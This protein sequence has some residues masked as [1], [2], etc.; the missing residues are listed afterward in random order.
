MPGLKGSKHAVHVR[1]AAGEL[2]S[3]VAR[4]LLFRSTGV[5]PE[6]Y[7]DGRTDSLRS[8]SAIA[9]ALSRPQER[10]RQVSETP[11]ALSS[12]WVEV[13]APRRSESVQDR[14]LAQRMRQIMVERL[15][16]ARAENLRKLRLLTRGVRFG[17]LGMALRCAE[18]SARREVLFA[19]AR[20]EYYEGRGR[21]RPEP[22]KRHW[23]R[24][25]YSLIGC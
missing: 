14:F 21:G 1:R 2:T 24:S 17:V 23:R 25:V 11:I 4:E 22:R 8:P 6:D 9:Y 5:F 13:S 12:S 16:G 18:R 20:L 10:V 7:S 15:A 19:R 3:P